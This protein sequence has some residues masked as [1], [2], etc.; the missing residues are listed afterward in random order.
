M[1]GIIG[2]DLVT[3]TVKRMCA[4]TRYQPI[5][6]LGRGAMGQVWVV[7]QTLLKREF[8]LKIL[9]PRFGT[10]PEV[11]DRLRL[12]A[13]AAARI[14]HSGIVQVVDFWLHDDGRAC[15]VM[16][17]LHGRNLAQELQTTPRI[18]VA[19]A[20]EIGCQALAALNAA[21]ALGVIH[22]DIK[23]DNL[24][25]H[26]LPGAGRV[27]KI[28]DFGLARVT[29]EYAA[30]TPSPP[31][32]RT[33]TGTT[34]GTPRYMSPEAAQGQHV[35]HRSDL[36]SLG[37]TL[38]EALTGRG[39]FDSPT[40]GAPPPPSVFAELPP[41]LDACVV[42]AIAH[43]P[44]SRFQTAKEFLDALKP[45]RRKPSENAIDSAPRD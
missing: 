40:D 45:L 36:Y 21:H 25:L 7:R 16:E 6:F 30:R 37:L 28:L 35:D 17:L 34:V 22:R 44:Q 1:A 10:K 23:P 29:A 13:Q 26:E 33:R 2:I 41:E 5:R 24:F 38:Y 14:E 39:P 4:G 18:P 3:E 32:Q 31:V 15:F 11:I 12:E 8:A 9:H 19:D 27:V 20:V 42:T 43:D